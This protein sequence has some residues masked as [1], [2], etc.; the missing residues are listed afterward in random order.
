MIGSLNV[1]DIAFWGIV[2][3]SILVVLHE[4]GHFLAARMFGVRVHEFMIGLPGPA[5][6]LTTERTT[7]GITAI[8]LGGY[9]RI[10]GMEPG[11][12][13]PLLSD[14]LDVLA[15]TDGCTPSD[16]AR[17]LGVET[18][19]ATALLTTLKD[20]GAVEEA[21]LHVHRLTERLA[22]LPERTGLLDAAR[23]GT[24]RGLTTW[25]RIVVLASGVLVN[26][27]TAILVFTVVLSVWGNYEPSLTLDYVGPDT[28]AERA[29]LRPGD[30]LMALDG[31]PLRSWEA[32]QTRMAMTKPG[33]RIAIT[34]VRA[35]T[36]TQAVVRLAERDGHG[37]LGV[38]PAYEKRTY[39]VLQALGKSL[40]WTRDVFVAIVSF[41]RPDTFASS[42]QNSRSIVGISVL[43]AESAKSGPLDYAGLIAVLSLSLGAMNLLPIPPLDGGRITLEVVERLAG[44]P[45]ARRASY[46]VSV[47]GAILLFSLIGYLMYA[48]IVR[49]AR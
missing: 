1:F 16:L 29:G 22:H 31:E 11:P 41:F 23:Q 8:P 34:Y 12:E 9:V 19:R 37:F 43:A 35:G 26:I 6:R 21:D 13:D 40:G 27:L 38:G 33:T 48:D 18:E 45:I 24:Y 15:S 14:A 3:F 28:P 5:I 49:L 17:A 39:T 44:R 2:T 47:A 4:G 30:R 36:P 20:W 7:F 10:A 46:A 32:F 42:V 25:K